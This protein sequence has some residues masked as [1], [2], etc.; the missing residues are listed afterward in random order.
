MKTAVIVPCYNVAQYCEKVVVEA[1]RYTDLLI[2]VDDGSRDGTGVIL[3]ELERKH[4]KQIHLITFP[5][6]RGKGVALIVGLKAALARTAGV[7]ITLDGDGQHRPSYIP[8]LAEA[9]RHG[10]DFAIGTRRFRHMPLRSRLGNTVISLLLRLFYRKAPKDTQSGLRAFSRAFAEEF[11]R[12]VPPGRYETEFRCLLLALAGTWS[13]S[14]IPISTIYIDENKSSHFSKL[15]DSLRILKVLFL[16]IGHH[17]KNS[18][19]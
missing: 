10:H 1:L 18:S 4:P 2:L 7:L 15:K 3:Q 11:V 6:N 14:T 5:K 16:H 8:R 19:S 12:C 17:G 13:I 9:I